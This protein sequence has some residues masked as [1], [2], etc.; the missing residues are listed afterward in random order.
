ML[1]LKIALVSS[2]NLTW[3]F[4]NPKV[5]FLLSCSSDEMRVKTRPFS[6]YNSILTACKNKTNYFWITNISSFLIYERRATIFHIVIYILYLNIYIINIVIY[7]FIYIS[8]VKGRWKAKETSCTLETSKT[9]GWKLHTL[10]TSFTTHDAYKLM[11]G[12]TN[13][14]ILGLSQTNF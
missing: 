1:F 6:Y 8:S 4:L 2:N 11:T 7:I 9:R 5:Q 3:I 10:K 12:V 14:E 13:K